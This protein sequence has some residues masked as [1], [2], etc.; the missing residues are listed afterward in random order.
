MLCDKSGSALNSRRKELDSARWK[1]KKEVKALMATN[2]WWRPEAAGCAR[3]RGKKCQAVKIG[4]ARPDTAQSSPAN[5]GGNGVMCGFNK[6]NDGGRSGGCRLVCQPAVR[7]MC[8]RMLYDRGS[9]RGVV[10]VAR[11]VYV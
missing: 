8:M 3:R 5:N 11:E 1:K 2:K 10:V 4:D 7:R 9:E 6:R